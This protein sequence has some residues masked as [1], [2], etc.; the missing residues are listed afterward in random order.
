[1]QLLFAI[2][3]KVPYVSRSQDSRSSSDYFV[4]QNKSSSIVAC[5]GRKM[6]LIEGSTIS[7]LYL[8]PSF[9]GM[10]DEITSF[11]AV[12]T[13]IFALKLNLETGIR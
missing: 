12:L 11:P 6:H 1:M 7:S 9:F 13:F 8:D 5:T 3:L 2:G 4:Y 10:R